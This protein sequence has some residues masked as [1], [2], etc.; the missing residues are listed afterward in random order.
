[1]G[2]ENAKRL[3]FYEDIMLAEWAEQFLSLPFLK[4]P[5]V[6]EEEGKFYRIPDG[7]VWLTPE[8]VKALKRSGKK[9][10]RRCSSSGYSLRS[11]STTVPNRCSCIVPRATP[12]RGKTRLGGLVVR[13]CGTR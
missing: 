12:E 3:Y 4:G 1:M 7:W 10:K 13:V 8:S 11:G 2:Q 5:F 9:K 6:V